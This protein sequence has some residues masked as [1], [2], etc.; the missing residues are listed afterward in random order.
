M[1]QLYFVP[2][3]EHVFRPDLDLIES[4][5]NETDPDQLPI[6]RHLIESSPCW[7]ALC[8][9]LDR[10]GELANINTDYQDKLRQLDYDQY[11]ESLVNC[12]LAFLHFT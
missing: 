2:S 9:I 6:I 10:V 5:W 1:G 7:I 4:M 12:P 3:L 8:G 11:C